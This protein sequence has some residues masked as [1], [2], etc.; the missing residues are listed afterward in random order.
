MPCCF[1]GATP[2]G[3]AWWGHCLQRQLA[4]KWLYPVPSH[5]LARLYNGLRGS[6]WWLSIVSKRRKYRSLLAGVRCAGSKRQHPGGKGILCMSCQQSGQPNCMTDSKNYRVINNYMFTMASVNIGINRQ[7][8][9]FKTPMVGYNWNH[10]VT[11]GRYIYL[12]C[13]LAPACWYW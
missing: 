5:F 4:C 12:E 13:G 8:G 6:L 7:H 10:T 1:N 3:S 9:S 11:K 2:T